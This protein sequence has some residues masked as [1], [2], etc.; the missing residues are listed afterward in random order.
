MFIIYSLWSYLIF[1]LQHKSAMT[2]LELKLLAR[3]NSNIELL[4]KIFN[5]VNKCITTLY[6]LPFS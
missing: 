2:N 5:Y 1:K 4:S 6:R 3:S